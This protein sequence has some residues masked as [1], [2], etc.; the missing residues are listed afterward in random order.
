MRRGESNFPLSVLTN[1]LATLEALA[2][3]CPQ[4]RCTIDIWQPSSSFECSIGLCW[5]VQF[6]VILADLLGFCDF[7]KNLL[8]FVCI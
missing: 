8:F 7:S 1:S 2:W 4:N 3:A 5:V 6:L